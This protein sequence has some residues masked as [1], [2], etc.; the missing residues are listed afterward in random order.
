MVLL[1]ESRKII[2]EIDKDILALFEKRMKAVG[3]VAEYK[4]ENNLPVFDPKR[5]EEKIQRIKA[6]VK[7][8]I[9]TESACE[10]FQ[11]IMDLSKDFE[12]NIL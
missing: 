5:E 8:E 4:R 10:L 6:L 7:N 9:Y 1:Q 12:N 2:D 3:D 11:K